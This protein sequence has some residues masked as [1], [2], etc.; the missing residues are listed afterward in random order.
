MPDETE[1][2]SAGASDRPRHTGRGDRNSSPFQT[3]AAF[4][5]NWDWQSIVGINRG[6]C[7]R[8]RAQHG[9]NSETGGTCAAEWEARRREIVTFGEALDRLKSFH[10]KAPFLFFNG[11]TFAAIAR[12]LALALFSDL[13]A[14][15]KR[16]ISSVIAPFLED[17]RFTHLSCHAG[18]LRRKTAPPDGYV[19]SLKSEALARGFNHGFRRGVG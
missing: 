10:R 15:R 3:R 11:N 18:R 8:S 7:E 2:G 14:I 12:Q 17:R 13:P 19:L 4:V 9:F 16:E 6:T 5:Q 1:I